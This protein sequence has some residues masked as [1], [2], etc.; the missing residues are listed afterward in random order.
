MLVVGARGRGGFRGLKFG[1]TADQ[2][3]RYSPVPVLVVPN[4][5]D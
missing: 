3:V 1:S 4:R 5:R 2:A